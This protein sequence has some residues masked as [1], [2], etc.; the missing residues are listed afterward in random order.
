[1][2][3]AVLAE[4]DEIAA[5]PLGPEDREDLDVFRQQIEVQHQSQLFRDYLRPFNCFASFW[6]DPAALLREQVLRTDADFRRALSMMRDI[7]RFFDENIANM[8][9]GLAE[10]ITQPRLVAE[11]CIPTIRA[12]V[13]TGG[14]YLDAFGTSPLRAEAETVLHAEVIPAYRSLLRFMT[15]EYAPN[16]GD[17]LAA[18]ARAGFYEAKIREYTTLDIT[19]ERVREIGLAEVAAV[20][21]KMQDAM[22]AAGFTGTMA[23]FLAHLRDDPQFYARSE[24]ELLMRAAW[25]CKRAEGQLDRF[26]THL[27]RRRFAIE[28]VP[29]ALAATYPPGTCSLSAYHLNTTNL[30]AQPLYLLPVLSLHEAVPGHCFQM[31]LAAENDS[32]PPFRADTYGVAYGNAWA[33]YCEKRL[34]VEMGIYRD[35]YELFGMWSSIGL[36]A[37]RMVVDVGLH[38]DGWT[39]DQACA[40]LREN[41]A[42]SEHVI[43]TEVDRYI[44]W[45]AQAL[46]YYLGMLS[47][48]EMRAKAEAALP[49]FDLRAFYDTIMEIGSVP[50]TVLETRLQRFI[51][52]GGRGPYG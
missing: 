1:M 42:L 9:Q 12:V 4:L 50:M 22:R 46:G 10:G 8:R 49:D 34:G 48:E 2:W 23:E 17:T 41:T 29:A 6:D 25:I 51:D 35:A 43:G 28:P 16:A 38:L 11:R 36:R 37:A 44:S 30:R 24:D 52:E 27:P 5:R 3:A 40:Y 7:P 13:E 32:H 14:T 15:E 47:T 39:R 20:S 21:A 45:P 31:A 33:L 19:P 26:F 18:S